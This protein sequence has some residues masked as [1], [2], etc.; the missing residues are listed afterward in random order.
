MLHC[1]SGRPQSVL[2]LNVRRLW[3][4]PAS[5]FLSQPVQESSFFADPHS[6]SPLPQRQLTTGVLDGNS[7]EPSALQWRPKPE[8]FAVR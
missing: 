8:R 1:F 6:P 5:F 7:P 2:D 4:R 3:P